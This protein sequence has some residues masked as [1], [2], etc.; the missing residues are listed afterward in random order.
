MSVFCIIQ[1]LISEPDRVVNWSDRLRIQV[2]AALKLST[3]MFILGLGAVFLDLEHWLKLSL[4]SMQH[5][6]PLLCL[7]LGAT[8][9]TAADPASWSLHI[10]VPQ[11]ALGPIACPVL[12]SPPR[13]LCDLMGQ[14]AT[15]FLP[16]GRAKPPFCEPASLQLPLWNQCLRVSLPVSAT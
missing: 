10:L 14:P 4:S 9:S 13:P 11:L 1:L 12:L 15:L 6:K 3:E 5:A 8:L 16:S 7:E 2:R